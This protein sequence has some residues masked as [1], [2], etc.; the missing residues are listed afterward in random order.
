MSCPQFI[1]PVQK[2]AQ[3]TRKFKSDLDVLTS[4]SDFLIGG[5]FI[6]RNVAWNCLSNNATGKALLEKIESEGPLVHFPSSHTHFPQNG[7]RPSTIDLI[8]TRGFPYPSHPVTDDPF[9]SDHVPIFCSLDLSVERF[10]D[11]ERL[12]K[13]FSKVG[14]EGYRNFIDSNVYADPIDLKHP[15]VTVEDIDASVSKL[16]EVIS[17]ADRRFVPLKKKSF[18]PF[19]LTDEVKMLIR[20]RRAKN[21]RYKRTQERELKAEIKSLT[22][23]IDFK[24]Q[25]QINQSFDKSIKD[26]DDDPGH[27]RKKLWRISR[28]LKNR[29]KR[30]PAL[31]H[32]NG[33]IITD[34]EKCDVFAN[35]F[36]EVHEATDTIL[37]RD[38]TSRKV[39]NSLFQIKNSH[40]R[41]HGR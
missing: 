33:R 18:R 31:S 35:H 37:R 19:T 14:L 38:V 11:A 23:E 40:V 16:V 1:F 24:A 25:R 34:Q 15:D 41:F 27:Y 3:T 39:K 12:V 30:I 2:N 8:L 13:D 29:P 7:N 26:I 32:G 9:T 22:A 20:I 4:N 10:P 36:Q 28:F 17:E 6:A 21:R 5:D